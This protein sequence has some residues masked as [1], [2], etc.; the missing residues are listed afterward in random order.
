MFIRDIL[1]EIAAEP[2]GLGF[3]LLQIAVIAAAVVAFFD[4]VLLRF[5]RKKEKDA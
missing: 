1:A 5:L 3:G 2:E 4:F